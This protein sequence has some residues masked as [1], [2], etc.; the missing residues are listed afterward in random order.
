MAGKFKTSR[1]CKVFIILII[2]Y[3]ERDCNATYI[4]NEA[5]GYLWFS[6]YEEIDVFIRQ[7]DKISTGFNEAE[8]LFNTSKERFAF[9]LLKEN[10]LYLDENLKVT[11]DDTLE[12]PLTNFTES[13]SVYTGSMTADKH[14]YSAI[15]KFT[16]EGLD[17]M[18]VFGDNKFYLEP[19]SRYSSNQ[20]LYLNIHEKTMHFHCIFY[21]SSNVRM[22]FNGSNIRWEGTLHLP[23][24]DLFDTGTKSDGR[25][26]RNVR[27]S[28][29]TECT[30]HVVADHLFYQVNGHSDMRNT[31]SE[32]QYLVLQ[33]NLIFRGTDFDGDGSGDNI[34]FHISKISV[35]TE[36]SS[37]K[38]A[39]TSGAEKYLE[40]LSE[41]DFSEYCLATAFTSR[42]FENG[43]IGLA[44]VASSNIYGSSGGI[45][46]HRIMYNS[47][48]MC[49]N[50]NLVTTVNSGNRIPSYL[51]ALTLAHE[52]GH[53]F[54]SPHD[55][56]NTN[57]A[58]EGD[59]G[60]YLMFPYASG[61]GKPNNDV[62]S[63][64][65]INYMYPVIRNKGT[66]FKESVTSFCG[67]G[68]REPGEECD[69]GSTVMCAETD[70][71]CTPSDISDSDP[72]HPC[73]FRRSYGSRCSPVLSKCCTDDCQV[74]PSEMKKV[75]EAESDCKEQ[76]VCDG[77]SYECPGQTAVPDTT[78]CSGGKKSCKDGLCSGSVCATIGENPCTC[79]GENTCHQCCSNI[80]LACLPF[81][82]DDHE[83]LPLSIGTSCNGKQGFCDGGGKCI[84]VDEAGAMDR[85]NQAFSDAET[86]SVKT[87]L[88]GQWYYVV[89][90]V[91]VIIFGVFLFVRICRSDK[92]I[93]TSAYMYGR[94]T[95]IQREA[96]LQKAY[97]VRRRNE[98]ESRYKNKIEKL[99]N[100]NAEMEFPT[101]VARMMVF[102][103]T[104]PMNV[105]AK[106]LRSS[107]SEEAAVRWLL[108]RNYP[109]RSVCKRI[110]N[111][112]YHHD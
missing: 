110:E 29:Q 4:S 102:F 2:L 63:S 60:N 42:D 73:T 106:T 22:R 10:V 108:L 100:P 84:S 44:W 13:L 48:K 65:S 27:T 56:I 12:T 3:A 31:M 30:L 98:I 36:P 7:K 95:G 17:G 77:I 58:P 107:A 23:Q 50:T 46:Q 1:L 112:K 52:I 11:V 24:P 92:H 75:C 16:P 28:T 94:F 64:C 72:D 87:W 51:S 38:M 37:Y 14:N 81:I 39:T 67:N 70:P 21:D 96:E 53:S 5:N 32:I 74:V 82:D 15:F 6:E 109:F 59:N 69:C 18:F 105:V 76:S 25:Y 91:L 97:L 93:Q 101:A 80:H 90:A 99:L 55:K 54:G 111:T 62:F 35:Y 66:C 34:G 9:D 43:V 68:L 47:K 88:K 104:A 40:M 45:C 78:P 85:L 49:L 8:V 79:S 33:A 41:Y 26:K 19:I 86:D 20:K 83:R 89:L 61:G 103:P 57:C 71:C